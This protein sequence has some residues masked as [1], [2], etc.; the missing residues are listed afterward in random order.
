MKKISFKFEQQ[1]AED[2][3]EPFNG[4]DDMKLDTNLTDP[5]LLLPLCQNQIDDVWNSCLAEHEKPRRVT[6]IVK[7]EDYVAL[8][9][10][11]WDDFDSYED[12]E[13]EYD[14]LYD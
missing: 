13:E 14:K 11:N 5:K 6:Q 8:A 12:N 1:I 2:K 4:V 3:W 9:K 10:K 7:V